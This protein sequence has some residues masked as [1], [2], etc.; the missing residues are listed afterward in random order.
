VVPIIHWTFHRRVVSAKAT[1][2]P[3]ADSKG[4][5]NALKERVNIKPWACLERQIHKVY[6]Q[7]S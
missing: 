6:N 1:A 5:I 4:I 3:L 7:F 2:Q